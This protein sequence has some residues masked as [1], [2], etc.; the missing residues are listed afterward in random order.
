MLLAPLSWSLSEKAA[1]EPMTIA[2]IDS[3]ATPSLIFI[4]FCPF[5]FVRLVVSALARRDA[6]AF[7]FNRALRKVYRF[8]ACAAGVR[9]IKFI[10]K[11]LFFLAALGTFAGDDPEIFKICIPGAMLGC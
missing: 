4:K 9:P 2:A 5:I 7:A 6:F 3:H 11:Y 10:R 1:V 8:A